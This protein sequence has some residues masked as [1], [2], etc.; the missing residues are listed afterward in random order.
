MELM[1]IAI[2][3]R[4]MDGASRFRGIG[5]YI[6]F[7]LN[8]ML[9]ELLKTNEVTLYVYDRDNL[10]D[11][12]KPLLARCK[13][14][15]ASPPKLSSAPPLV[16]KVFLGVLPREYNRPSALQ[17]VG[18]NDL[19]FQPYHDMGIPDSMADRSIVV[20][21]DLIP[22]IF[23]GEYFRKTNLGPNPKTVFKYLRQAAQ[24]ATYKKGLLELSKAERVIAI[25]NNTKKDLRKYLD[26]NKDKISVVHLGGSDTPNKT[27]SKSFIK[28]LGKAPYITYVGGIDSR[29]P[30]GNLLLHSGD[31]FINHGIRT[32]VAGHDFENIRDPSLKKVVE[33]GLKSGAITIFGHV[34]EPEKD[35]LIKGAL[36][37]VYPTLYEGF[38]LPILESFMRGTPVITYKN[39]SI[40][41]VA[42]DAVIYIKSLDE[43]A[44]VVTKLHNNSNFNQQIIDLG[45]KQASNFSWDK[46]AAQTLDVINSFS[47]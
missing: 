36:A 14:I 19:F 22:L 37:F 2:D 23:E 29:R 44:E 25:S 47:E 8:S 27:A 33:G 45:Y 41:E 28:S 40:P 18:D 7:L 32:I 13:I 5:I 35:A 17:G 12:S 10:S 4:A 31:I 3:L 34:S 39:S 9:P 24:R 46:C 1:K 11:I 21:Y 6:V 26:I 42:G 15:I 16:K 30:I 20:A 38:G 43:I